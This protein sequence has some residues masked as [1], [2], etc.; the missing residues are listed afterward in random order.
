MTVVIGTHDHRSTWLGFLASNSPNGLAYQCLKSL[1][2]AFFGRTREAPDIV[3]HGQQLYALSL[4]SLSE[5]LGDASK[6]ASD[7]ILLATMILGVY[8]VG[9]PDSILRRFVLR[10]VC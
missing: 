5:A 6:R 1:A 3:Q 9:A 7:D 2:R 10:H 4:R 8:E